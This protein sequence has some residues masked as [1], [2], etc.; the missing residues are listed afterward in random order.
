MVTAMEDDEFADAR[1]GIDVFHSLTL[2]PSRK[3]HITVNTDVHGLP[4]FVA[5]HGAPVAQDD[6]DT[7][8]VDFA[9]W[10]YTD[11]LESCSVRGR[12]CQESLTYTGTWGDGVPVVPATVTD[13]PIDVGPAPALLAE[14]D[15]VWGPTLNPRIANCG[16]T[17]I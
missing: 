1:M 17:H 6:S 10:R 3:D 12:S 11:I 4:A 8:G 14:C 2:D 7:D 16:T 5:N 9:L 13:D 15:L